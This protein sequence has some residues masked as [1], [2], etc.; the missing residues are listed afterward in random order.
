MSK[1]IEIIMKKEI[2][3]FGER[4]EGLCKDRGISINELSRRIGVSSKTVHTWV[5]KN[6]AS[7]RRPDDLKKLCEFFDVSL[8]FLV[9]GEE[10]SENIEA[11]FSK[12][13]IHT[14]LYEITIKRVA[15]KDSKGGQ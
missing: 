15:K 5:G 2:A 10:R 4:L 7:P 13:E 3:D 11:L 8:E 1:E 6:G 12:S 9:F 14:G